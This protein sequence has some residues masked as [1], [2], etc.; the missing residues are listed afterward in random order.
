MKNEDWTMRNITD[1]NRVKDTVE[2][3][4][5]FGF[6]VKVEDFDPEKYPLDCNECMR[7]T[8]ENFK[9]IFTRQADINDE[10]LFDD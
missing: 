1:L 9:V 2:A 3:Y 6:E 7:E 4:E 5:S 10:G 8:P